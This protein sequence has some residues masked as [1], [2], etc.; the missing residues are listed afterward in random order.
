MHKIGY[1]LRGY[2][3][4]RYNES[5]F[6][7]VFHHKFPT[8]GFF[9]N[10]EEFNQTIISKQSEHR[11]NSKFSV[12]DLIND[13]FRI[14]GKFHFLLEYPE[15]DSHIEWEQKLPITSDASNVE[16]NVYNSSFKQ[17]RGLFS[18]IRQQIYFSRRNTMRDER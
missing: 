16:H 9:K 17:F 10:E 6:V 1:S 2:Q 14:D 15:Y 7:L 13:E 4:Q 3:F 11:V 5:N 8:G 18:I 12:I